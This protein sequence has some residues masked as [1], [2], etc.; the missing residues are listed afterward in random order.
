[1]NAKF[2]EDIRKKYDDAVHHANSEVDDDG[3]S[4]LILHM[5][6]QQDGDVSPLDARVGRQIKHLRGEMSGNGDGI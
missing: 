3:S 1:M 4:G 6:H 2:T 5:A